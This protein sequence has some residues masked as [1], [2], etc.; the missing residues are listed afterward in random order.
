MLENTPDAFLIQKAI[1]E[2]NPDIVVNLFRHNLLQLITD[3]ALKWMDGETLNETAMSHLLCVA[4][5][6][7]CSDDDKLPSMELESA[8]PAV[9]V[10]NPWINVATVKFVWNALKGEVK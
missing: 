4:D 8:N 3:P 7:P 1:A 10:L 9:L 2:E 6:L 5:E